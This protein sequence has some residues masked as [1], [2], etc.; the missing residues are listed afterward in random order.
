MP[1]ILGRRPR[2]V[3]G[4]KKSAELRGRQSSLMLHTC[5]KS[6][7]LRV[8]GCACIPF[9]RYAATLYMYKAGMFDNYS[10]RRCCLT[11]SSGRYNENML[12][13]RAYFNVELIT[14]YAVVKCN[15]E[16]KKVKCAVAVVT[17]SKFL[18]R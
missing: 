13:I 5:F 7:S 12:S 16:L 2:C 11:L 3:P 17:F 9:N 4:P 10:F 8:F 6:F 15:V 1:V 18:I 14:I